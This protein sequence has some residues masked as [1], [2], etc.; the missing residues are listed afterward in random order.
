MKK[1]LKFYI[2]KNKNSIKDINF[3][4]KEK[5]FY[6]IDRYVKQYFT[7]TKKG[8]K[9]NFLGILNEDI[10]SMNDE[11]NYEIFINNFLN[12]KNLTYADIDLLLIELKNH[13]SKDHILFKSSIYK[14]I[15][16][17]LYKDE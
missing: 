14:R 4:L 10:D 13:L 12:D 11:I 9:F 1:L 16:K 15:Q 8:K 5:I 3:E 7:Y 17:K 2:R 6:I